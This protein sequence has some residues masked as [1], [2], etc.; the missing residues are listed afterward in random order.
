MSFTLSR[1]LSA[2]TAGYGV[3]ALVKPGHLASGLQAESIERPGLDLVAYTYGA[4]DVSLSTVALTA[5]SPAVVTAVMVLRIVGD[6]GDAAIL[7]LHTTDPGVR[8]KVLAVTTG[9]A[10]ANTIALLVDRR[11][12]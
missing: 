9:W 8:R 10:V 4:R 2:A 1:V 3:F 6:L 7:G 11:R 5:T 12:T